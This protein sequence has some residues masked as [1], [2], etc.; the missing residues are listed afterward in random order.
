MFSDETPLQ[1]WVYEIPAEFNSE[2]P[3][4]IFKKVVIPGPVEKTYKFP[5]PSSS[6]RCTVKDNQ[7][8][9]FS[10]NGPRSVGA[11]I[12]VS[13]L[14]V[15][16][17]D[18]ATLVGLTTPHVLCDGHGNKEILSA[19]ARILRGEDVEELTPGDPFTA[20]V[21]PEDKKNEPIK[22][23][24]IG[25]RSQL[26]ILSLL[27]PI[28]WPTLSRPGISVIGRYSSRKKRWRG[29]RS[30]RRKISG[31]KRGTISVSGLAQATL[32]SLSA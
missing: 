5:K 27:W 8:H 17:F 19:V 16:L 7:D 9:L 15:T 14:Q 32:L 18:D 13:Q 31:K 10:Q 30:K 12:P 28:S 3:R 20:F 6:I 29:S 22:P 11:Y 4:Y 1:K 26:W 24:R 21:I 2:T 25:E 23:R